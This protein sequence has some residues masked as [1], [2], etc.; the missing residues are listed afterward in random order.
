MA[1]TAWSVVFGEQPTAAKWNQLGANDAGFKD[2]TNIDNNAIINRHIAEGVVAL[3]KL[4]TTVGFYATTTQ[5]IATGTQVVVTSYTEVA[6]YGA[7]FASGVF[8][9][10]VD[11]FYALVAQTCYNNIPNNGRVITW[12]DVNGA[13]VAEERVTS[14]SAG[15]DPAANCVLFVQLNAGDT[16]RMQTL[17]DTGSTVAMRS[18]SFFAGHLIGEV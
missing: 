11:G 5:S 1:Y 8:T 18:V 3:E 14:G 17:H 2:G 9:A 7:D 6:D 12:I 4:N 16:C 15:D 13:V 10:P